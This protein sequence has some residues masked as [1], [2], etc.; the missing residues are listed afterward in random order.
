M[1]YIRPQQ[2]LCKNWKN[3][4]SGINK[5][6]LLEGVDKH[7]VHWVLDKLIT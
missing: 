4:Y 6:E 3:W 5:E 1:V 7:E 2:E